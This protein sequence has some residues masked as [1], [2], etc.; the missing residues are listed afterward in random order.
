MSYASSKV[1]ITAKNGQSFNPKSG[2]APASRRAR[3][4]RYLLYVQVLLVVAHSSHILDTKSTSVQHGTQACS[5]WTQRAV[6]KIV[7]TGSASIARTTVTISTSMS[8][9]SIPH[10]GWLQLFVYLY[11]QYKERAFGQKRFAGHGG[12]SHR[13]IHVS[14]RHKDS[15]VVIHSSYPHGAGR[16]FEGKAG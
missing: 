5:C 16:I 15:C 13:T 12:Q 9:T 11:I 10:R 6:I 7:T 8:W 3:R 2:T 4:Y 14:L 1:F